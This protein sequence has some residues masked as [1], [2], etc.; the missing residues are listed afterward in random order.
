MNILGMLRT[1]F[2]MSDVCTRYVGSVFISPTT[3][4][5]IGP[6][7]ASISFSLDL[8]QISLEDVNRL[9]NNGWTY[10]WPIDVDHVET[11]LEVGTKLL[12]FCIWV[13]KINLLKL[14]L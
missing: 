11:F 6:K 1:H 14:F 3:M 7:V 9:K 2:V 4:L 5:I 10:P 13:Y 8:S 12:S